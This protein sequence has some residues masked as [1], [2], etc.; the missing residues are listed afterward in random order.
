MCV[1]SWSCSKQQIKETFHMRWA[2]NTERERTFWI[3]FATIEDIQRTGKI[4]IISI[5]AE[6]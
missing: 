3:Q 1:Y 6:E 4:H 5:Y 2:A